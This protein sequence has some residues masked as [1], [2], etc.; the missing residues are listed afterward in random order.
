MKK[1]KSKKKKWVVLGVCTGAVLATGIGM[2]LYSKNNFQNEEL[3]Y[4]KTTV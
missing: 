4:K 2:S 3:A 1:A